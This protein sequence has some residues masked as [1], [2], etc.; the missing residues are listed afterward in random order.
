M[1]TI[2]NISYIF[3]CAFN[4]RACIELQS[5]YKGC[6]SILSTIHYNFESFS[7][8]WKANF[9]QSTQW[10]HGVLF[11]SLIICHV[12]GEAPNYQ[13]LQ[14]S[15]C[16]TPPVWPLFIL[17]GRE[18]WVLSQ[19]NGKQNQRPLLPLATGSCYNPR[20]TGWDTLSDLGEKETPFPHAMLIRVML[21]KAFV[22]SPNIDL[23]RA[24]KDSVKS[25]NPSTLKRCHDQN[26]AQWMCDFQRRVGQ[27]ANPLKN[28]TPP[29]AYCI[30]G[31]LGY[32]L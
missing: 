8:I 32:E 2:I 3:V 14:K 4:L 19:D 27:C 31:F 6:L 13:S 21:S 20:K 22:R 10:M 25:E 7:Q 26:V 1:C 29:P 12:C 18:S 24:G 5:N 28:H 30:L 9:C 16:S 17:S 11:G 15:T 23:M